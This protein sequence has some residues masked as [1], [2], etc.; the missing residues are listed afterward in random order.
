MND[1][2]Q[3][4]SHVIKQVIRE[5]YKYPNSGVGPDYF[6]TVENI[7]K[8]YS[9]FEKIS[10]IR[11][12]CKSIGFLDEI[13]KIL[14]YIIQNNEE[15]FSRLYGSTLISEIPDD[16]MTN[17]IDIDKHKRLELIHDMYCP[18]LKR[19]RKNKS[20]CDI[21]DKDPTFLL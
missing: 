11:H 18:G 10:L 21:L 17:F 14:N 7:Y 4:A 1:L 5:P 8:T 2:N 16:D 13:D 15:Y 9:L 12:I 20:I 19:E 3:A 6:V